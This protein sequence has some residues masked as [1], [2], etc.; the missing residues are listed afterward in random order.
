MGDSH[1]SKWSTP[2]GSCIL[3][4]E[5]SGL[6]VFFR[7]LKALGEGLVSRIKNIRGFDDCY[8]LCTGVV[9]WTPSKVILNT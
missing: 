3:P 2:L 4:F 5:V 7:M 6:T 9:G 1:P 8:T